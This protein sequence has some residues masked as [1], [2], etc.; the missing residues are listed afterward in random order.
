MPGPCFLLAGLSSWFVFSAHLP[1]SVAWV[2]GGGLLLAVTVTGG[3]IT[4]VLLKN[5]PPSWLPGVV[6][7]MIDAFHGTMW[8]AR[9]DRLPIAGYTGIIWSLESLWMFFLLSAFGWEL[10]LPEV[11]FLTQVPLLASAFPLTPS[12]A[13]RGGDYPLRMPPIAGRPR[14]T[15][16]LDHGAEPAH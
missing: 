5:S 8:P 14:P 10:S 13:R 11:I 15:G 16:G 12:G 9:T 2:L 1:Q 6:T 4:L 3:L 7:E